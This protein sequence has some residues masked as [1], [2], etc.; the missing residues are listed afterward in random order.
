VK[1]TYPGSS[2]LYVDYDYLVTGEATKIRENGATSGAGVLASFAY[3]DLG[4]RTSLTRGN[5]TSTSYGFDALSRLSSLTQNP[6]GAAEDETFGFTYNPAAQITARTTTNS[7]APYSWRPEESEN[8]SYDIDGLNRIEEIDFAVTPAYDSR[9]NMT[10]DGTN[11]YVYDAMNRL[12]SAATPGSA[13][14]LAYDPAGRLYE[15]SVSGG[16]A[17]RF[18]YDGADMIAEYNGSN[19]LLRRYVH[20]PGVDEPL[21]WYEG[22]GLSD[23]RWLHQ[24]ERGSVI[25]VSDGA[26]DVTDIN[27]YD[28][29][30][31]PGA[32]NAGRFQY[33]GQIWLSEGG[34][35]LYHYK[36]RAYSPYL[37]RFLQTDPIGF[38]G[39]MNL[40]AYVGGDPINFTDPSGLGPEGLIGCTPTGNGRE[41]VDRNGNEYLCLDFGGCTLKDKITVI[42]DPCGG[43]RCVVTGQDEIDYAIELIGIFGPGGSFLQA[44]DVQENRRR[45]K[46]HEREMEDHYRKQGCLVAPQVHVRDPATGKYAVIDLVVRDVDGTYFLFIEGKTGSGSLSTNQK[47]VITAILD[48]TAVPYGGNAASVGLIPNVSLADQGVYPEVATEIKCGY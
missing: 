26:G 43:L 2:S 44:S 16:A 24:D 46:Q 19:A 38:G 20:G 41:C 17:T 10:D 12:T 4:R 34:I 21:V 37:G 42:G 36:A 25:S 15:A 29:Y 27:L 9:G 22:T 8:S 47:I 33:T 39:G 31:Q 45:A 23:R 35:G 18:L 13:V 11:D 28:A 40:Y 6:G 1:L 3:D 32:S 30:G 7:A 5:G 48:G 14:S